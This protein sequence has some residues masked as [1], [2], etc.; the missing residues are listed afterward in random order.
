MS[1]NYSNSNIIDDYLADTR[2]LDYEYT[3]MSEVPNKISDDFNRRKVKSI[4]ELNLSD[5]MCSA[6]NSIL[7]YCFDNKDGFFSTDDFE[8]LDLS[9]TII[10]YYDDDDDDKENLMKL[11]C[12][13][14]NKYPNLTI[15][16]S[17]TAFDS[18]EWRDKC[19]KINPYK[20]IDIKSRL[21]L[22]YR[23]KC[24]ERW[25][26][27]EYCRKTHCYNCQ[28]FHCFEKHRYTF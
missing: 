7:Q 25:R 5:N 2:K 14:L 19:I 26:E 15:N 16:L 6:A 21:I 13:L 27:R 12:N 1:F 17:Y 11:V 3:R 24:E 20:D 23:A 10:E 28:C 8:Y 22:E 18:G 4:L 9:R